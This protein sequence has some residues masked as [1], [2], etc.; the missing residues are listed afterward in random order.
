[1]AKQFILLLLILN[2]G[3]L[4]GQTLP[5]NMWPDSSFSP[6]VHGV[7]SGDPM[8]DRIILWTQIEPSSPA[9]FDTA[10]WEIDTDSSFS[11]VINSGFVVTDSTKDWTVKEDVTGLSQN[12]TYY[13]RFLDKGGNPSRVGRTKTA[14]VG[15]SG[16]LK[17]AVASC[18]IIFS[19]FFNAYKR[20]AERNDIDLV[21][22]LG[23]YIYNSVDPDEEVRIPTPFPV[24]PNN[25]GEW[26][27]RHAYYLLD[28]DLR[29][30]RQQHPFC[31]MWDNHDIAQS[32]KE[33]PTR[34]FLEWTPTRILDSV[35]QKKIFRKL[36]YG[37][38]VDVFMLDIML[39]REQDSIGPGETSI[40][41]NEQYQ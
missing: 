5:A 39:Y 28:P 37:D 6:F 3:L 27:E 30:A 40:L 17:F 21:I 2:W 29:A 24:D 12:T 19:G 41:G 16:N 9:S 33:I 36:S 20:I 25:L 35:D 23:D 4:F 11:S 7:A 22:H 1:M 14:P 15:T 32:N 34:A 26:R 31:L 8:F 10:W 38:L 18:S 13:Y